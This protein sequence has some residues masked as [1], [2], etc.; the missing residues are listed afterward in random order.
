MAVGRN[1]DSAIRMRALRRAHSKDFRTAKAFADHIGIPER[2]WNNF[3]R[4]YPL[5]HQAALKICQRIPG[6]TLDWL[7]VGKT[8]G[9]TVALARLLEVAEAEEKARTTDDL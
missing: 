7:H 3:E 6:M 4:G 2:N 1:S 9:L 8:G 5:G